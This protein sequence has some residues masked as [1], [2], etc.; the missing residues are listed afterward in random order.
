MR[1]SDVEQYG[2][3]IGHSYS[4]EFE[5]TSTAMIHRG[6]GSIVIFSDGMT[7]PFTTSME[8]VLAG[9][10]AKILTSGL[11]W[12]SGPLF[13]IRVDGAAVPITGSFV[14]NMS[15]SNLLGCYAF[16]LAD[17]QHRNQLL[18]IGE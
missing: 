5:L 8:D 7:Q 11:P 9:D 15:S 4:R 17:H 12:M 16:S 18:I 14:A 10:V 6:N 2:Q 1:I 13:S 3:S